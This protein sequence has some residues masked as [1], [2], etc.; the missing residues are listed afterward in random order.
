MLRSRRRFERLNRETDAALFGVQ[1]E[2]LH[3]HGLPGAVEFGRIAHEFVREFR[4]V[5]EAVLIEPQIN[6]HA[7]LGH[8]RDHAVERLARLRVLGFFQA[9]VENRDLEFTARIAARMAQFRDKPPYQR[10]MRSA[11]FVGR[12]FRL[13][14]LDRF[15]RSSLFGDWGRFRRLFRRS[16]HRRLLAFGLRYVRLGFFF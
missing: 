1:R 7:E 9:F 15:F 2:Y 16:R 5:H 8:V 12:F 4:N 6:K 14:G 10:G 3:L 11:S 13:S